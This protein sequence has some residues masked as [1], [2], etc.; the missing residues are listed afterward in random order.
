MRADLK[1]I[2]KLAKS[3]STASEPLNDIGLEL[4]EQLQEFGSGKDET[5]EPVTIHHRAH[6]PAELYVRQCGEML[7][8]TEAMRQLLVQQLESGF[9]EPLRIRLEADASKEAAMKVRCSH[10]SSVR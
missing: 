9:A 7:K 6:L 8:L 3:Y 4:A 5:G 2:S 1:R 10:H